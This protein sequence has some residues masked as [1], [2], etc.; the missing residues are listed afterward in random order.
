MSKIE[1]ILSKIKRLT[2]RKE[3]LE[4]FLRKGEKAHES[5]SKKFKKLDI[6]GKA[7]LTPL[8]FTGIAVAIASSLLNWPLWIYITSFIVIGADA[9][10]HIPFLM[11]FYD[12]R[13]QIEDLEFHCKDIKIE[14]S[15]LEKDIANLKQDLKVENKLHPEEL[16]KVEDK[17]YL[18]ELNE[19]VNEEII[20]D[21]HAL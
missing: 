9:I 16:E 12:L 4:E 20:E 17:S 14:I 5:K 15:D 21:E 2:K 19:E 10:G 6:F 18:E 7:F 3:E 11:K 1:T 8:A 13:V